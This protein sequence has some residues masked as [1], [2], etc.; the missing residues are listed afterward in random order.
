MCLRKPTFSREKGVFQG[1]F[2]TKPI[3]AS[4]E[5]RQ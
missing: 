4:G 1:R 3:S 2:A 5:M